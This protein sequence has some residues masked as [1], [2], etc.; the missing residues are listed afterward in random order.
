MHDLAPEYIADMIEKYP[1]G[2]QLRH[3]GSGLP[4]I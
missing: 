2:H 3:A 4:D 1:P